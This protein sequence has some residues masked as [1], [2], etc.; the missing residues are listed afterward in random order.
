M[1]T[2]LMRRLAPYA[3]ALLR[4]VAGFLFVWHGTQKLFAFPLAGPSASSPML[5]TAAVVELAGGGLVMVGFVTRRVAFL[6]SAEMAVASWMVHARGGL[7]PVAH[8]G[9]LAA[10]YSLVFLLITVQG[11]GRW[12]LD[13][14]L[15]ISRPA[16]PA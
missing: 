15:R 16:P 14:L 1:M 13:G 10:L 4:I 11:P 8:G 5:L 9:E 7:F 3:Y 12:S 2:S 6:C